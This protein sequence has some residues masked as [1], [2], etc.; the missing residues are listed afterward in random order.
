MNDK[1]NKIILKITIKLTSFIE[2]TIIILKSLLCYL[3]TIS[4]TKDI[5]MS[6]D[7]YSITLYSFEKV[8]MCD[9]IQI[10]IIF[11]ID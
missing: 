8:K 9:D 7:Q 5:L 2:F 1:N 3:H 6:S 10:D 11:M 4:S